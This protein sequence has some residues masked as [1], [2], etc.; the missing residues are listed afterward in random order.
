M[1]A[2]ALSLLYLLIL[3]SLFCSNCQPLYLLA[4]FFTTVVAMAAVNARGREPLAPVEGPVV[5][6]I[7]D[8][9]IIIKDDDAEPEPDVADA[10]PEVPLEPGMANIFPP[11]GPLVDPF[12]SDALGEREPGFQ[13]LRI[14][15]ATVPQTPDVDTTSIDFPLN[16]QAAGPPPGRAVPA[17]P[18]PRI[19]AAVYYYIAR[20]AKAASPAPL[21]IAGELAADDVQSAPG[22]N[23]TP[24]TT[25]P[26][27]SRP[28]RGI[29]GSEAYRAAL[30]RRSPNEL[31]P[32]LRPRAPPTPRPWPIGQAPP[33][34]RADPPT[35]LP[36]TASQRARIRVVEIYYDRVMDKIVE[37]LE[38]QLETVDQGQLREYEQCLS[39]LYN[40]LDAVE[41]LLALMRRG[42]PSEDHIPAY[43][44]LREALVAADC[45]PA[46]IAR[47]CAHEWGGPTWPTRRA[48][49]VP[50]GPRGTGRWDSS[51]RSRS[52][53][54]P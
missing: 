52:P 22:V 6:V 4:F 50:P 42:A 44:A 10:H 35:P 23:H 39:N 28:R 24:D 18:A 20:I 9:D 38:Y 33:R 37:N 25:T 48:T 11:S 36:A 32:Y 3:L 49:W 46:E 47:L 15:P 12:P 21:Y 26:A 16:I 17:P 5:I 14:S 8:E 54:R 1:I 31:P 7:E 45:E 41:T 34:P 51:S 19:P 43:A 53:R 30:T 13:V 29:G 2:L 40:L 27:T